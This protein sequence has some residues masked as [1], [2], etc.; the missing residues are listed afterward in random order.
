MCIRVVSE[1]WSRDSNIAHLRWQR[2][3]P[4][5]QTLDP[6]KSIK[7]FPQE[8]I[9]LDTQSFISNTCSLNKV[10]GTNENGAPK[11]QC[12]TYVFMKLHTKFDINYILGIITSKLTKWDVRVQP[13]NFPFLDNK[14]RL[15]FGGA[16]NGFYPEALGELFCQELEKHKMCGKINTS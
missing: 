5:R 12:P 6:I 1:R 4:R 16:H 11:K 3:W 8:T 13:K 7:N 10:T 9:E 15:A 2:P 14:T